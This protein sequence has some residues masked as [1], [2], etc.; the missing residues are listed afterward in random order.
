M[1]LQLMCAPHSI[2]LATCNFTSQADSDCMFDPNLYCVCSLMNERHG[3]LHEIAHLEG[4]S[5]YLQGQQHNWH[6]VPPPTRPSPHAAQV[7]SQSSFQVCFALID[8]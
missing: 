7:D 8:Q 2:L 6:V 4:R 5:T 3:F 1:L